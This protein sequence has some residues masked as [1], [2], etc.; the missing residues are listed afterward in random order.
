MGLQDTGTTGNVGRE[1]HCEVLALLGM[2]C[3]GYG[4]ALQ[5]FKY[6]VMRRGG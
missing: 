6:N 4:F 3:S 2:I 5:G 1:K